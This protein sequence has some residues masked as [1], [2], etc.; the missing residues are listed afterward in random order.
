MIDDIIDKDLQFYSFIDFF[1][2]KDKIKAKYKTLKNMKEI[3]IYKMYV[4]SMCFETENTKDMIWEFLNSDEDYI[5]M[6]IFK[7][8][9][10][11]MRRNK[12]NG[13]IKGHTD[14]NNSNDSNSRFYVN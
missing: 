3:R 5:N 14:S 11:R 13:N 10:I 6:S 7:E 8:Y 4:Y 12:R 2:K 1:E 9:G